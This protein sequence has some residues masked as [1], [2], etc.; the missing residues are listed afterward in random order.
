[1]TDL[2]FPFHALSP[3]AIRP[4]LAAP[5]GSCVSL[6]LP[7]HR[8]P[9][10]NLVDR[11]TYRELLHA[12]RRRLE[13]SLPRSRLDRLM[14]PLDALDGHP[15]FWAF[16]REGLAIFAA[17]KEATGFLLPQPVPP[18]AYVGPRYQTLPL[19]RQALAADSFE[20]LV[21]SGHAAQVYAGR[22]VAGEMESLDR[23]P[24]P[25][26]AGAAAAEGLIQ[27]ADVVTEEAREP[28]RALPL[29]TAQVNL[30]G[31]FETRQADERHDTLIFLRHVDHCLDSRP[32]DDGPPL[33]LAA[34]SHLAGVFR[35]LS[36]NPRLLEAGID[37]DLHGA[38][39]A[40]LAA[41][42]GPI[43]Q[44][45]WRQRI[46]NVLAAF[47]ELR[48]KG[49]ASAD[50]GCIAAA[51][52]AGRIATLAIERDRTFPGQFDPA[53]GSIHPAASDLGRP[54][55]AG[56]PAADSADVVAGIAEA[57]V[58]HRGALVTLPPHL[59]KTPSGVLA[60]FRY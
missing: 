10:E 51:A 52:V 37:R 44:R 28:H 55:V 41:A 13:D 36:R 34:G 1:M 7:T 58:L 3:D 56:G 14:A 49:L 35:R 16:T 46:E 54:P 30:H 60:L 33:I 53:T 32:H 43:M 23:L 26:T 2:P 40:D 24:L 17:A 45:V 38:P 22:T 31:G 18:T 8:R 39:L 42:C 12:V 29:R 50:L 9:P 5:N 4:L 21:L 47:E 6:Y 20:V 27:R 25:A 11:P 19:V 57:V 48:P 59:S 15:D